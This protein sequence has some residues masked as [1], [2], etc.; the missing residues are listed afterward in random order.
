MHRS[1][2][3]TLSNDKISPILAI[4][5]GSAL[6]IFPSSV[7]VVDWVSG[8][9]FLIAIFSGLLTAIRL[10]G[11]IFPL[12]GE[13]K[14][15]F[16]SMTLLF[17]S[18]VITSVYSN[19]ELA[20]ADRLS[21]FVFAIPVYIFIKGNTLKENYIWL[22]LV[23]G[24]AITLGVAL[25][26]VFD[27]NYPRATGS[28]N[29]I[30]FGNIALIMGTM[31]LAGTGWFRQ[32]QKWMV[33]LPILAFIA[34]LTTSALSGSRGG[35]VALPF[36]GLI[37]AWYSMKN[38]SFKKLASLVA[39]AVLLVGMIY[40]VPQTGVQKRVAAGIKNIDQYITST[41]VNDR[42]RA[43]SIGVRFEMWKSAWTIFLDNPVLGVGWGSFQSE[44]KKLVDKGLINPR[45]S[46][47]YHAHNQYLSALAKGGLLG[48]S[49][50]IFLVI[51]PFVLFYKYLSRD[52]SDETNRI[53]LAGL[54]L[55]VGFACFSLSEAI[56]ERSRAIVFYSFYTATF[57][58]AI[59]KSHSKTVDT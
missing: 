6:I 2:L 52:Y 28:I 49:A 37:L 9:I 5:I 50:L 27:L 1:R 15:F 14:I 58:A 12:T 36:L 3:N 21:T 23:I 8:L 26:Q 41:D 16:L 43:T 40:L 25:Y 30:M 11:Q 34:G 29:P 24:S 44:T 38:L 20:R 57:L 19:T 51:T 7:I 17:L 46:K 13:E 18:A 48:L 22:G 53:A 56:L 45:A 54:V 59:M 4:I 55:V 47:Y 39:L 42:A 10:K 33:A 35:W 31:A 32:Q